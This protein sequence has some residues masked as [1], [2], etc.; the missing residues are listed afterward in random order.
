MPRRIVRR[1]SAPAL[2]LPVLAA[3]AAGLALGY[4]LATRGHVMRRRLRDL[5]GRWPD[6]LPAHGTHEDDAGLAESEDTPFAALEGRVLEAFRHDP[7]LAHRALDI[8]ATG[9]DAITLSGWVRR[10][11]EIAHALTIARGT[12]GVRHVACTVRVRTPA[13]RR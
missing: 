6:P 9:P 4:L 12:P 10:D 3:G 8:T 13:V 5:V 2:S 11:P 1:A 7:V